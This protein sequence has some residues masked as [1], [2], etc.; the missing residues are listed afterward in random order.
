MDCHLQAFLHDSSKMLLQS[1]KRQ[2]ASAESA[3]E[4]WVGSI[5]GMHSCHCVN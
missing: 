5:V 1:V 3:A 4:R 2:A